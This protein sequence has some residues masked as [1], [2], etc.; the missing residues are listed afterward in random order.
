MR[1]GIRGK[2]RGWAVVW[3]GT[4]S[5]GSPG[6]NN[7]SAR[8]ELGESVRRPGNGVHRDSVFENEK[9]KKK[10]TETGREGERCYLGWISRKREKEERKGEKGG[11][12]VVGGV[13]YKCQK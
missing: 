12:N 3:S 9:K 8:F 4:R 10:K 13:N 6:S 2:A 11:G 1:G 7:F 5:S